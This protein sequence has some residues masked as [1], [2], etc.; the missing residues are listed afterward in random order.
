MSLPCLLFHHSLSLLTVSVE[1]TGYIVRS[2]SHH[3][4]STYT[5][6]ASI[7]STSNTGLS[8]C[9]QR[10]RIF[11]LY[12]TSWRLDETMTHSSAGA[13]ESS[14][15]IHI[16]GIPMIRLWL[17]FAWKDSRLSL[18]YRKGQDTSDPQRKIFRCQCCNVNF[19]CY[20]KMITLLQ[21]NVFVF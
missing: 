17:G 7:P 12:L 16:R 6:T 21:V 15:H 1:M 3:Y 13:T 19:S 10:Q 20:I 11:D 5:S 4:G 9:C 18:A 2:N 14:N 8:H